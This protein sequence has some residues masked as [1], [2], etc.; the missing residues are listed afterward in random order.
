MMTGGVK[1]Q[2]QWGYRAYKNTDKIGS[3]MADLHRV[4][5]HVRAG[6]YVP[7]YINHVKLYMCR[8]ACVS[9]SVLTMWV[10]L[11]AYLTR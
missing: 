5:I 9:V 2:G 3:T 1:R 8:G 4:S 6:G 11:H 10:C 7:V